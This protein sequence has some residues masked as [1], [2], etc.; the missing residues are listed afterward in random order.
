MVA[1]DSRQ[2][3]VSSEHV[4]GALGSSSPQA[5]AVAIRTA[6]TGANGHGVSPEL[7]HTLDLAQGQAVAAYGFQPRIAR[8]GRG[9]MGD[10]VS[11]LNAQSGETGKGDAL[12]FVQNSRDEVRL[13]GGD[14]QIVGALAAE[15]GS[16]QQCYVTQPAFL[17]RRLTPVECERLQGFPD[18]YTRIPWRKKPADDCPDGPRYKALGNSKCVNVVRWLGERLARHL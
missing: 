10:L 17:V 13:M 15:T 7:A 18:D 11:A 1:F 2:D 4:F 9:D 8:N 5:Q 12:A 3:P 16:K 14:G 6:N